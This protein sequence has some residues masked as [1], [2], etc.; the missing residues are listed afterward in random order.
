LISHQYLNK[1]FQAKG[2]GGD[3]VIYVEFSETK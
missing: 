3:D 1:A 2:G